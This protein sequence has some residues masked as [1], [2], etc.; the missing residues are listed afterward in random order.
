MKKFWMFF[1]I[2]IFLLVG[3]GCASSKNSYYKK[4]HQIV[5][6]KDYNSNRGL[7]LLESTQLGR[8]KY[9]YSKSNQKKI[10]SRKK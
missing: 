3:N 5:K 1:I 4:K 10:K 8:N 9:F 6:G 2:V 7:M